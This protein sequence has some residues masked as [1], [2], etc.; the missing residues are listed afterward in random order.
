[1]SEPK[2]GSPTPT[3][4]IKYTDDYDRGDLCVSKWCIEA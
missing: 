4:S 3:S 1:M 2:R